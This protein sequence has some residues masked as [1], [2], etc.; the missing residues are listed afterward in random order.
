MCRL[1]HACGRVTEVRGP[2]NCTRAQCAAQRLPAA[3][4]TACKPHRPG[5]LRPPV[6]SLPTGNCPEL[7][8]SVNT[9][10][11]S[12]EPAGYADLIAYGRPFIA[13][14]DLPLR[15]CLDAPLN[16]CEE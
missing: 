4:F 1:Q 15:F 2:A 9:S 13:N 16:P 8:G 3:A 10:G 6:C 12:P 5:S 7:M 11:C 14:P